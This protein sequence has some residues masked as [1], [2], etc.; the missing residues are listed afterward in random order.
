M[1]RPPCPAALGLAGMADEHPGSNRMALVVVIAPV[2]AV[3]A[4]AL[5]LYFTSP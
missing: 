3:L 4:I 2:I 5:L 1:R